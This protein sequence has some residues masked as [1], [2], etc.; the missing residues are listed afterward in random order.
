VIELF[1]GAWVRER[2]LLAAFLISG[3]V[4]FTLLIVGI[5]LEFLRQF[6][7]ILI[8]LF[9]AWLLAFLIAPL[10][11]A[12]QERL[13]VGRGA[14]TGGAFGVLLI[15]LAAAL[16][17]LAAV[18]VADLADFI[19][20]W[21]SRE[22]QIAA[23]IRALQESLGVEDPDIA[24][25]FLGLSD[26]IGVLGDTLAGSAASI[27]GGAFSAVGTLAL[28]VLLAF[29]MALDSHK[30]A[31]WFSRLVPDRFREQSILLQESVARSFGS[32]IRMQT[33]F[34]FLMFALV[35]VVGLVAREL[36]GMEYVFVTAV[37]SAL[38]MFIP[39]IG[40]ALA[41][42]PPIFIA[43]LTGENW[44]VALAAVIVIV[45]VQTVLV[46]ALQPKMMQ[47]SLGLHPI[48]LFVGLLV[49]V[50]VAGLWGALF[51]IPILA[52]IVIFVNR[53]MDVYR[54]ATTEHVHAP[55]P[56]PQPSSAGEGMGSA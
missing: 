30:I 24:A 36:G 6:Q 37:V 31:V 47:E 27:A 40:P 17:V 46:N 23:Q 32:F 48:L 12:I 20:T 22:E 52:V 13:R 16:M 3:S 45:V 53:W 54:P 5:A 26:Q 18:M 39:M 28:V 21:P 41:L 1:Q 38:F 11:S 44:V 50:Q 43:F 10:V 14:A 35:M 29:F 2:R 42:V 51:T 7:D 33:V 34:A 8:A 49:G 19:A 4:Y 9:L 55:A 56:D 15:G 25:L